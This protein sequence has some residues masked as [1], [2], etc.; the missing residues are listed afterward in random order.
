MIRG[1]DEITA[2]RQVICPGDVSTISQ[3]GIYRRGLA[4]TRNHHHIPAKPVP[5]KLNQLSTT[6]DGRN[7]NELGSERRRQFGSFRSSSIAGGK[8]WFEGVAP[9][10]LE[11]DRDGRTAGV[12]ILTAKEAAG[13]GSL[14]FRK[15]SQHQA[16][17]QPKRWDLQ[18]PVRHT[19]RRVDR[20]SKYSKCIERPILMSRLWLA[21]VTPFHQTCWASE[22]RIFRGIGTLIRKSDPMVALMKVNRKEVKEHSKLKVCTLLSVKGVVHK[23]NPWDKIFPFRTLR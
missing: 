7:S 13:H 4:L 15:D 16:W 3:E 17:N 14:M 10:K 19:Q 6:A 21:K 1:T 11:M 23:T 18:Y 2:Q 20:S 5:W 22:V 9:V 12:P 8:H